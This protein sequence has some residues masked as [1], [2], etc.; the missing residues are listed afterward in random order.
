VDQVL[1]GLYAN[2]VS[3]AT[4]QITGGDRGVVAIPMKANG[5]ATAGTVYEFSGPDAAD[6]VFGAANTASIDLIFSGGA[7]TVLAYAM[8][9]LT[10]SDFTGA[11][12]AFDAWDFNVFV[13]DGE[14]ATTEQDAAKTWCLNNR[15]AGKHFEVVCGG[16]D[17]TD[18]NP[19]TGN[20]QSARLSDPYLVNLIN[21]GT[22]SGVTYSSGDYAPY[23]AGLIAGTPLNGSITY[24][25]VSLEDVNKRLTLTE[26]KTAV[27]AGSLVFVKDGTTVRIERGVQ[28]DHSKIRKMRV[29]QAMIT[30]L[31]QSVARNY[32]GK[33]T[34]NIDGQKALIAAIKAYLEILVDNNV[35]MP[36][37][38]VGLDTR[39]QSVGD[40]V[41][42]YIKATE[43]DSMEEIYL[44][45]EGGAA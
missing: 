43:A 19:V 25:N 26:L 44:S 32:I 38:S 2:F 36:D 34:N 8:A 14:V 24:A 30:D 37:I 15:A 5:T 4:A 13:F 23:V 27:A 1:A 11:R 12:T 17:T 45:I 20:T 3:A 7:K 41:F 42:I 40:R 35:L 29:R 16:T 9:G 31:T 22:L 39:Y 6:T 10:A 21:G 28:T 33:V 18:L